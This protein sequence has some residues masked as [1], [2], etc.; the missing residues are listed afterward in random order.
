MGT[1][2]NKAETVNTEH[3]QTILFFW[4]LRGMGTL[5]EREF[6]QKHDLNLRINEII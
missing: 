3:A 6:L 2:E 4:S 5:D 1:G